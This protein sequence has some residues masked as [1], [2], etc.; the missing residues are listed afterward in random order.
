MDITK[1]NEFINSNI[2]IFNE[3][4]KIMF[5]ETAHLSSTDS[6][7]ENKNYK[8]IVLMGNK[9]I[10]HIMNEIL[11]NDGNIILYFLVEDITGIFIDND[12]KGIKSKLKELYKK[13]WDINEHNF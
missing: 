1:F 11:N 5:L 6:I 13:W 4:Y 8:D 7:R 10:P 9:I 3:T 12:S 2:L